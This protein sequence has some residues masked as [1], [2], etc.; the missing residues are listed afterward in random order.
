MARFTNV[1]RNLAKLPEFSDKNYSIVGLVFAVLISLSGVFFIYAVISTGS[2]KF[3]ANWNMFDSILMWPLYIIGL[4]V[5]F[6]NWN[7]FSFS[8]DTYEKTTYE[9]GRVEV[10]R[11]W[12]IM[13]WMLGHIIFPFFGRFFL[14][15]IMVAA[16]IYYPLMCIIHLVGSIFPYILSLIVICIIVVSW[17]F[18]SWF[19]FRYHS[20]LIVLVG[21]F[22]TATFV[23]G[24]YIIADPG[25]STV[26]QLIPNTPRSPSGNG[27]PTPT[28]KPT[29]DDEGVPGEDPSDGNNTPNEFDDPANP[30]YYG[31]GGGIPCDGL[32]GALPYGTTEYEGDMAG[33]PIEF[34]I[35][36]DEETKDLT[37]VYKNIK[38]GTTMDLKGEAV[39]NVSC[40]V[41]FIGKDKNQEWIFILSGTVKEI[42]G[43]AQSNDGKDLKVTLY[44][45]ETVEDEFD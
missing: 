20:I 12:D 33:F 44:N 42:T 8:F 16:I 9:D 28:P 4:I 27:Q 13:E 39:S 41:K 29:P 21:I 2:L 18:T 43:K 35:T 6:A 14:V 40:D 19:H 15:P 17:K 45:K 5:M 1:Q 32:L 3:S 31:G 7:L 25:P 24:G 11:N 26:G 38:Y 10:K 36:R 30:T 34:I 22:F 23:I 37:A